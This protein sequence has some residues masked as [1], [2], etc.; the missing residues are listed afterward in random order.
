MYGCNKELFEMV[1]AGVTAMLSR[2]YTRVKVLMGHSPRDHLNG[3]F[4]P[5]E[6]QL[7]GGTAAPTDIRRSSHRIVITSR[8]RHSVCKFAKFYLKHVESYVLSNQKVKI[9][10]RS[11]DLPESKMSLIISHIVY[12]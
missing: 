11:S 10:A 8:L 7:A 5:R 12:T 9:Q 4:A 6:K 2:K 1:S 3:T